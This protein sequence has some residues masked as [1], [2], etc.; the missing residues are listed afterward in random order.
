MNVA[1]T[2][3][4]EATT[5]HKMGND[6][7]DLHQLSSL[8]NASRLLLVTTLPLFDPTRYSPEQT[9]CKSS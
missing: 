8:L 5:L 1:E 2:F 7:H 4:Y 9:G 3:S 6:W